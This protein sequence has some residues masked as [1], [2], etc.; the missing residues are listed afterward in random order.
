MRKKWG[1]KGKAC[2]MQNT[3][4]YSLHLTQYNPGQ[5]RPCPGYHLAGKKNGR[6]RN[7]TLELVP[8]GDS[9]RISGTERGILEP[10]P[11]P[12]DSHPLS[13]AV[14]VFPSFPCLLILGELSY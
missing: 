6:P 13:E 2:Y 5:G 4:V 11:A 9:S 10:V 3:T 1:E 12:T 7:D 8:G 14:S